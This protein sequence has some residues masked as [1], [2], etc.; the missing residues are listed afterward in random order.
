[1]QSLL[2]EV[3]NLLVDFPNEQ[4]AFARAL[5]LADRIK[6]APKTNP[7]A[8]DEQ[9]IV[10][11]VLRRLA[12]LAEPPAELFYDDP[13]VEE[14]DLPPPQVRVDFLRRM[15]PAQRLASEIFEARGKLEE[16]PTREDV[17]LRAQLLLAFGRYDYEGAGGLGIQTTSSDPHFV[18]KLFGNPPSA[19]LPLARHVLTASLPPLFKAHPKLNPSTGR[20]LSRPLGG[21]GALN[22]WFESSEQDVK[23]WRRQVGL[24]A[25][26][27]RVIGVLQPGEVEDLWPFLLP[28]LLSYLDDFETVNKIRGV[29]ILDTLLAR[30]DASLLRR[31]GVGKVFERSLESCFSALSDPSTPRLLTATYPVALRLANLQYPPARPSDPA[32]ADEARFTALCKLFTSSIIHAWEFKGQNVAIETVTAKALPPLLEAMGSTSIR[33]LQVLVPHLADLLATTATAGNG[34]T[35][36]L[37]TVTLMLET[38][39]ALL[40]VIDNARLRIARWEGKIGVAVAQCWVGIQESEAAMALRTGSTEGETVVGKLEEGLKAVLRALD[41]VGKT[42]IVTRLAP[43][44]ALASLLTSLD[45]VMVQ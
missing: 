33:Y 24:A 40:A 8:S 21:E 28:P 13:E 29:A 25:V 9:A 37:E 10:L 26:V 15:V 32:T 5:D 1:M 4:Q 7:L 41:G 12:E 34:G 43:Y 17:A 20:V 45:T 39:R 38:S 31:T 30:V 22:T 42:P 23:S 18:S 44:P 2:I 27:N 16:T 6:A 19:R 14:A 3:Q 36:T 11:T 35:W